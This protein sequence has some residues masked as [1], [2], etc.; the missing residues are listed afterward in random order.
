MKW[1]NMADDKVTFSFCFLYNVYRRTLLNTTIQDAFY[2]SAAFLSLVQKAEVSIPVAERSKT[3]VCGR[4]QAGIAGSNLAG[5]MDVSGL[6]YR[7]ISDVRT[8][9]I[10]INNG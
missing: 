2:Q 6:C 10:K 3:R 1:V 7:K 4:L 5:V 9:D 8:E